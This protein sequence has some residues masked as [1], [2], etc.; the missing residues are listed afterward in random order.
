MKLKTAESIQ[1]IAQ[2]LGVEILNDTNALKDKNGNDQM[3]TGINEI[4]KVV[5]G[6][7][8]FVD[9]PKYYKKVLLSAADFVIINQKEVENPLNKIL[10]YSEDPFADYNKLVRHFN[11]IV[12]PTAHPNQEKKQDNIDPTAI[13]YP[14]VY[15][16]PEVK[17]GA[18]SIIYPNVSI[19]NKVEIGENVI[20]HSNSTIGAD[21][22]YYQ[23]RKGAYEPM[24]SCGRVVLHDNV[25][26]GAGCTIDRGVSGDTIVGKGTKIDNQVHIGH[27]VEIG[28]HCLIAAQVGIAGKTILGNNVTIWGQVG[29][30]KDLHIGDDAT[31]LA[32]SGVPKSLEGGQTY[33][34]IPVQNARQKMKELAIMKHLPTLWD[35]MKG[36]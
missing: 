17:I 21:A 12:H 4:H 2:L 36:F 15:L 26:I 25:E 35:K 22:F 16:G 11:P 29:I 18:N 3:V 10:L 33:F 24:R 23:K 19:Y 13:V 34:G 14:N 5:S 1:N 9:H 8:S 7:I 32:K 6:D 28:E 20:V 27:G 31:I 30:S